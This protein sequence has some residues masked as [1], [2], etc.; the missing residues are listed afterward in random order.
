VACGVFEPPSSPIAEKRE[1]Q[2][3]A[4]KQKESRKELALKQA[5]GLGVSGG[6]V[7]KEKK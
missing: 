2:K 1:T 5:L 7:K 4:I 6:G 3:N